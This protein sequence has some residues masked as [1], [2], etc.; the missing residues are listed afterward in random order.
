MSLLSISPTATRKIV[1]GVVAFLLV[2]LAIVRT[3]DAAFSAQT[4]NEDN[5]FAT[6]RIGLE[7]D[8]TQALFD[9][10]GLV[11]NQVVD[12]CIEITYAGNVA[13]ANL[14][15]VHLDVDLA[16]GQDL[17]DHL[18]VAMSITSDCDASPT[19]GADGALG[20]LTGPTGWTP[21]EDGDTRGF[22]FRVTVD[23]VAPQ[24]S[25]VSG[26]DLTWSVETVGD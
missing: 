20:D 12:N 24:D 13:D 9:E 19:Y 15:A 22:R 14:A 2:S 17:T 7:N 5:T 6:G 16:E 23:E 25:S 11:P 8:A 21:E 18:D 1:A 4:T 26:I 10:T 3:S